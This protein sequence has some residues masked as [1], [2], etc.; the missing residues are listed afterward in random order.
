MKTKV[1][2]NKF[3]NFPDMDTV[4]EILLYGIKNGQD[5][6][7]FIYNN[8]NDDIEE[9]TYNQLYHDITGLAQ[10]FYKLGLR[11]K[12]VAIL[13]ENSYYWVA[14]FYA[15]SIGNFTVIPLDAK[16]SAEDITELMVRSKC[17]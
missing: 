13:G 2:Y 8:F 15:L 17:S 14:I 16:L 5:N 12:K 4:K 9:K 1:R 6:K 11:G 7:C 10:Y 3:G